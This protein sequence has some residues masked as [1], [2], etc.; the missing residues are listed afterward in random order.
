MTT[1]TMNWTALIGFKLSWF[2]LVL[3]QDMLLIPVLLFIFWSLWRCSQAER[4]AWFV[5][6][7]VGITL[8]SLL[9]YSG[10]LSFTNSIWLPLWMLTLWLAF[11]L[12]VVQVFSAYLQNY[13]IA[14]LIAAVS[15]PMAYIG[16]A[17]L[18]G[19]MHVSTNIEAY[20]VLALCWGGYGVLSGWSRKFYA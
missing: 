14:A 18:S 11:G 17:A 3:F 6:A 16:G 2:A 19:Q 7:G 8:D 10:V 4:V 5:L 9:Q 13:W 1:T 12:V 20:G 15:G